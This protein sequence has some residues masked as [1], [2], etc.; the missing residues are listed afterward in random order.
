MTVLIHACP[1]ATPA[2]AAECSAR[3]ELRRQI[4]QLE[5]KISRGSQD[6]PP[7]DVY[8]P[9]ERSSGPRTR[10]LDLA[11]LELERDRLVGRLM[12]A[13]ER[14][15]R[16]ASEQAA[17]RA[18]LEAMLAEPRRFKYTRVSLAALGQPGCGAYRCRPRVGLVGML[19][20]WWEVKLSSG[21][22]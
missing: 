8:E 21:C 12:R 1:V 4:A 9:R 6:L 22:P 20:G 2:P 11:E 3:Q 7:P 18:R 5:R 15:D 17:V 14:C 16:Q 13:R 19:A 10:M